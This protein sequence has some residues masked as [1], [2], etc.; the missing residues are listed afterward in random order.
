MTTTSNKNRLTTCHWHFRQSMTLVKRA[1]S[2][3]SKPSARNWQHSSKQTL[4]L[5]ELSFSTMLATT[6]LHLKILVWQFN[7]AL[8][9]LKKT[10]PRSTQLFSKWAAVRWNLKTM[11][12]PKLHFCVS[13]KC[14]KSSFKTSVCLLLRMVAKTQTLIKLPKLRQL[15]SASLLSRLSLTLRR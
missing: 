4:F 12:K 7:F 9:T 3:L 13:K 6:F 11:K 2:K 10:S 5:D 8:T 1:A 14:S 15:S